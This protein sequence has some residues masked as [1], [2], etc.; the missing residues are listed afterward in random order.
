MLVCGLVAQ[1]CAVQARAPD[2]A[3]DAHDQLVALVQAKQC[4]KALDLLARPALAPLFQSGSDRA[5]MEI[6]AIGLQCAFKTKRPDLQLKYAV[7]GTAFANA[8]P[9]LWGAR[10]FLAWQASDHAGAV[11]AIETMAQTAPGAVNAIRIRLLSEMVRALYD[12][13]ETQLHRRLLKVLASPAYVPNQPGYSGDSFRIDY[14][15]VLAEDGDKAGAAE[16][17]A[18]IREPRSLMGAAVDSRLRELMPANFDARAAV[19]RHMAVMQAMASA[20]PDAQ[21]PVISVAE[22]YLAL[23]EADQAIAVLQSVR[24]GSADGPKYVD[25][26]EQANWWWN[27]LARAYID[28]NRYDDAVT[29]YRQG[30]ASGE[31]GIATNVSQAINLSETQNRFGHYK[32]ALHTLEPLLG[33]NAPISLFGRMQLVESHGCASY[34]LG[35]VEA[36]KTDLALLRAHQDIAPRA[37]VELEICMNDL[38]GAAADQIARLNQTK[39]HTAA[40]LELSTYAPSPLPVPPGMWKIGIEALKQRPDIQAAIQRAGGIRSFNIPG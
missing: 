14:A 8:S 7:A 27:T 25:Q 39:Q 2:N 9:Y 3:E 15:R 6:D 40:L 36:A 31:R 34:R 13:S 26:D 10:V 23:G 5:R 30:V 16:L 37:I 19:E 22:D 29:A 24:P 17:L 11:T 4:D 21:E 18:H 32:E 38:D 1:S 20:H 12:G 28:L 35:Q 33:P